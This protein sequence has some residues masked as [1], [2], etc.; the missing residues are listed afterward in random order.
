MSNNSVYKKWE[1]MVTENLSAVSYV[2]LLF[3][4]VVILV[5]LI[6]IYSA[7][8][9]SVEAYVRLQQ[10]WFYKWNDLLASNPNLQYN[11]T[12]LGDVIISFAWV[13][14]LLLL[15][16]RFWTA[17]LNAAIFSLVVSASLKNL[18]GVPRPA[19]MLDQESFNIIG[20][21]LTGKTSLP[22]GHSIAIF[23][24]IT[25]LLYAFMPR[26]K[27][28]K[29][30]WSIAVLGFGLFA[31]FTRVG[32]GAHYPVDVIVGCTLGFAVTVLGIIFS[33]RFQWL[34]VL[35]SKKSLPVLIVIV[36]AWLA[37]LISKCL[38]ESLVIYYLAIVSLIYSLYL[39]VNI[40]VKEKNSIA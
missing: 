26:H 19:A 35:Q 8:A 20:A 9:F 15:A 27:M 16:P 10:D 33:E 17:L 1:S 12:Q 5:V 6:Y 18:F 4:I 22:S 30:L 24:V 40:Y 38:A 2:H 21:T 11:L 37:F 39:L 13:S 31:A 36:L 32:V 29:I 3:P 23:V 28:S 14:C 34:K 7:D 25:M